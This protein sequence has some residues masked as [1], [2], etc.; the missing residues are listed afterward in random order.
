MHHSIK[1]G[2]DLHGIR[3]EMVIAILVAASVY[4]SFDVPLVITSV[5]DSTHSPGS[6]HYVGLGV[7]LRT[8]NV[9]QK[10][11]PTLHKLLKEAL[12]VQFDTILEKDHIHIEF[13][14]KQPT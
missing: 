6:K 13:D 9:L 5:N 2:V 12:G 10:D 3:P 11:L 8:S 7:D 1:P 4:N 14:P